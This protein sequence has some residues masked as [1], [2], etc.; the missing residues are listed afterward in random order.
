MN[1]N[2]FKEVANT[3]R[4]NFKENRSLT[5]IRKSVQNLKRE[6]NKCIWK[7]QNETLE[8]TRS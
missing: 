1:M 7:S 5:K 6:F 4:M 8:Q 2:M 3:S